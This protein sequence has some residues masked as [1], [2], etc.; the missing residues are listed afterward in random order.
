MNELSFFKFNTQQKD[1]I[2]FYLLPTS[3]SGI[4]DMESK[5]HSL[6]IPPSH[7]PTPHI[8]NTLFLFSNFSHF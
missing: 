8:S 5:I 6:I 7:L 3:L 1:I 2:I 4:T